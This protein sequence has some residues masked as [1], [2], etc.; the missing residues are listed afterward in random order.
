VVRRLFWTTLGATVGVVVGI[1]ALRLRGLYLALATLGAALVVA[2][3]VA[4]FVRSGGGH[5]TPQGSSELRVFVY[6]V[7]VFLGQSRKG[8]DDV[9]HAINGAVSCRLSPAA[10]TAEL[11]GVQRNRR[12]RRRSVPPTCSRRRPRRRSPPTSSIA[13]GSGRRRAARASARPRLPPG[14][15]MRGRRR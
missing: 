4:A 2:A 7:E 12:A 14:P 15:R 10:A 13:T 6:K 11:D 9:K 1:P 5:H 3:S 8:R